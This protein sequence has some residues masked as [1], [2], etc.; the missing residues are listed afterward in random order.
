LVVRFLFGAFEAGA[1]PNVARALARWF[2]YRERASAQSFIWFSSRMGGA[3]AP[4]IIGGLMAL[5]G[6][7]QRAFYCLGVI[8]VVWSIAFFAW[9][10]NRP[11]DQP[12]VSQ[13][14][15]E[16]I[17]S[18]ADSNATIYDDAAKVR[19]RWSSLFSSNVLALGLAQF[20]VSFCFYFYITFLP[21][22]L[23][24]QFQVNFQQSQWI[25]GLPLLLGGF[26]CIAGGFLSDFAIRKMGNR[27][28]G[29]SV[30]PIIGWSAAA[31]CVFSVP[32]FHSARAVMALLVVGFVFQDLGVAAMWSV[33]ADIGGRFTATVGGWMNMAGCIAAMLSPLMSA[34]VSIAYGWNAMFVVF[35]IVYLLGVL[36][37]VRIDSSEQVRVEITP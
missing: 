14:E 32:A 27:R 10:R 11:E 15:R 30:V 35:G 13:A 37:W 33:P 4:V 17:R 19:L 36:A 6:S 31:I 34:K 8:G 26:A 28:W 1:Y 24:D 7:W 23:K 9:F 16:Y 22:Y 25:S 3:F 5:S 21:R 29:R 20:A 2:P 12:Q 18:N